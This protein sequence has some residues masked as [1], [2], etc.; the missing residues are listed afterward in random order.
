[1]GAQTS[2]QRLQNVAYEGQIYDLAPRDV[3]TG[4]VEGNNVV[5]GRVV[6]RGTEDQKVILGGSAFLGISVRALDL[7]GS[8]NTAVLEYSEGDTPAIMRSGYI[9]MVCLSGCT[10]GNAAFYIPQSV[11]DGTGG[12]IGSGQVDAGP[13]ADGGI[14]IAGA[15]WET[16]TAAGEIGLLRIIP[17]AAPVAAG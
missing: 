8:A 10:P 15:T 2:Y 14:A 11:A 12:V 17:N 3:V 6:S 1:M 5:P 9:W 13:P 7:E 4:I 16:T